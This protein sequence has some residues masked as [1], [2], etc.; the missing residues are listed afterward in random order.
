[1][2]DF[3]FDYDEEN[4][5]LF[6]YLDGAKSKGAVEIGNFVFDFDESENLVAIEIFEASGVFSKLL[7][8]MIELTNIKELKAEI[9]NFRNMAAIQIKITTDSGNDT[10]NI[11]IPCIKEDSPALSY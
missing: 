3:K 4:D 8:K 7:A 1:M 11:T 6:I 2:R 9:I 10:A 5:D